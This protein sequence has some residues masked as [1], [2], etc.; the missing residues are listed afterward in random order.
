MTTDTARTNS[1]A[2]EPSDATLISRARA[3]DAGAFE[4]LVRRYY[5]AAFIVAFAVM[6][7]RADAEDV[8]HDA[9]IR[10]LARIEECREPHRF[11]QW[12]CTI[13]RNQAKNTLERNVVRRTE[14]L[15]PSTAR[16]GDNAA[17][18]LERS[19]LRTRLNAAL[20]GLTPV[21]REVVLLHDMDG[22]THP[23]IATQLSTSAGMSRQHLFQARRRL[24]DTLGPD[25]LK[26]YRNE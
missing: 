18:D 5:R 10:V 19:E 15:E 23:E 9:L 11:R 4:I 7:N 17:T 12:L 20:A 1:A 25:L 2:S 14:P 6:G 3:N 16:S 26:E 8:C 24:R 13:V 21:Q 22:W